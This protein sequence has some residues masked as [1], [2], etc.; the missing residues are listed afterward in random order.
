[1]L[2]KKYLIKRGEYL[3]SV[4]LMILTSQMQKID[5][6][7]NVK[8]NM[9]LP[10]DYKGPLLDCGPLD[11]FLQFESTHE[12]LI[13]KGLKEVELFFSQKGADSKEQQQVG[14]TKT[15]SSFNEAKNLYP[16]SNVALISVSG[17]Y[18]SFMALQAL[19]EN[20]HVLLFSDNVSL[21]EERYLKEFAKQKG[22]LLM[23][24]DCG[25]AIL[26]GVPLAFANKVRKGSIGIVGASGTGMQEVTSL[27][28]G[29]GGGIALAIGTGGR[30]LKKEIGGITFLMGLE[31][32]KDDPLVNTIILLSKPPHDEV[33]KKIVEEVAKCPKKVVALFLGSS[34]ESYDKFLPLPSNL[35]LTFNLE[36]CAYKAYE[37]SLQKVV[38]TFPLYKEE[39]QKQKKRREEVIPKLL[40]KL[41]PKREFLKGLYSG[42]TLA[43]EI[44]NSLNTMKIE[45]VS[46]CGS[47]EE[48]THL[49][50]H[51]PS[52]H[53]T[54]IDFGEDYF[55]KG[56]LHPMIDFTTRL[57]RIQKEYRDSQTR[58]ILF[59]L[60]LGNGSHPNPF[61]EL[62]EIF[63]SFEAEIKES[64][65][66]F[67]PLFIS[68]VGTTDDQQNLLKLRG[69]LEKY[70]FITLFKSHQEAI[71]MA[72]SLLQNLQEEF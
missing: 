16:Q 19:K 15:A 68:L 43:L 33:L 52:P 13:E 40:S 42:G 70:S 11:L 59:D 38:D 28:S 2:H 7:L 8:V 44:Q 53:H 10:A 39:K 71:L 20:L 37:L 72:T 47:A 31:L 17:T 41:G 66:N 50:L 12:K 45:F 1:M 30:D 54:I 23:G 22:L 57:K 4:S 56:Q 18:A 29:I 5:T 3:D 14:S 36:E 49:D 69:D 62:K 48:S 64:P 67:V 63:D 6:Q 25:T 51:S 65:Y 24:P 21:E 61:Q 9:G 34:I 26:N 55:T 32:L 27:L 46:N 58:V 35:T 60:V